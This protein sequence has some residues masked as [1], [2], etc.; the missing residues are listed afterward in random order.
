MKRSPVRRVNR[1]R[2]RKAFT[3]AFGSEERLGWIHGQE[4][5]VAR[6]FARQ[7][8]V[9]RAASI[10]LLGGVEC[11]GPIE[12]MHT[13][14]RGAGGKAE[15]VVPCCQKH[16]AEFHSQGARSTESKYG[17]NLAMAADLYAARYLLEMGQHPEGME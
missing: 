14:S 7:S 1:K 8:P 13:K 5:F 6:Y 11:G 12:A 10:A 17:V 2:R 3:E 16:H 15:H 4:C 9:F